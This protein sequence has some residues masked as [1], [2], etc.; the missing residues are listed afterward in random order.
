[1]N[2]NAVMRS[3]AGSVVRD[4]SNL[5]PVRGALWQRLMCPWP[6]GKTKWSVKLHAAKL[7]WSLVGAR[8]CLCVSVDENGTKFH[9]NVNYE[10][11]LRQREG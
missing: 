9:S 2:H 11:V 3:V 6:L 10:V 1:M 5:R 8:L 4:P 7:R